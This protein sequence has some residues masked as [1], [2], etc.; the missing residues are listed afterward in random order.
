M[1]ILAL[2]PYYGGSHRYFIDGLISG[3]CH[4]WTLLS[5]P[6]T[7]W[8]W[9]I[10]HAAAYFAERLNAVEDKFDLIFCSDMLNV[11]ELR[12]LVPAR[13]RQVP[14]VMYF[15]ENQLAYPTS[16]VT[17]SAGA[18]LVNFVS[19][20]AADQV[21]F[22]S[23]FNRDALLLGLP[24]FFKKMPDYHPA[25][26]LDLI[27]RK[28]RIMPLFVENAAMPLAKQSGGPLHILWAARWELD[29]NPQ[30][31][32]L[33]LRHLK[34]RGVEFYL[35]VLGQQF[36]GSPGIFKRARKIFAD[37][38]V[39]WGYMT[40]RE[41]YLSAMAEADV[42]VSTSNHE[43]FGLSILEAAA[44][45]VR[46]VLPRRLAYPEIFIDADGAVI[47]DYFFGETSDDLTQCLIK[48]SEVKLAQGEVISGLP[49]APQKIAARY[50]PE[51]IIPLFDSALAG[52][53]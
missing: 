31:F 27:R 32:F 1:R 25:A 38:I 19:A 9:R 18:I 21:W 4:Q 20:L 28:S 50:A 52:F 30:D 8:N 6:D 7:A 48:L 42:V 49:L 46:P 35:S 10:L 43:F 15:H 39:N 16:G 41:A 33:A 37:N 34:N 23:A 12:G 13:L 2:E 29:K 11:A 36:P 5:L 14:V 26:Q 3:S 40:S 47:S 24:E 22:N 17:P 51:K 45:G 53:S 44:C